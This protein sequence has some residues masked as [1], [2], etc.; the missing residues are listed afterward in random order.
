MLHILIVGATGGLGKALVRE[1]LAHKHSVAVLV[2]DSSKLAAELGDDVARL[3]KV[4]VGDATNAA[5][6]SAACAGV[7]VIFSGKG[8]DSKLAHVLATEGV[9]AGV[10]KFVFVAGATNV[11]AEDGVTPNWKQVLPYWPPA[12]GAYRAHQA[13]IDAIRES[14]INYVV[15]CPEFMQSRGAKTADVPVIRV[16]RPSGRF[17]SY[18]DGAAVMMHAAEVN[19]YDGQLIT[20][21]TNASASVSAGGG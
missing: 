4:H 1:G 8:G 2:R 17:V 20:A 6:V 15:F 21:A 7:D 13:C 12:E 11:L 9:N 14:G 10:K 19:T 5:T 3:A 18:E 16:N